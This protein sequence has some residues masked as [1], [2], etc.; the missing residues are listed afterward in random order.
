MLGDLALDSGSP[1]VDVADSAIAIPMVIDI[2]AASRMTNGDQLGGVV[3]DMGAYE[4]RFV[5]LLAPSSAPI[6]ETTSF[7]I[8]SE[9]GSWVLMAGTLADDQLIPGAGILSIDNLPTMLSFGAFG[10]PFLVLS[11][12]T[13]SLPWAVPQ[14]GALIG[15]ELGF[16][17]LLVP[18]V[19]GPSFSNRVRLRFLP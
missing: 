2:E 16:Q 3:A 4:R 19:G 13:T 9:P 11:P 14:L 17:A 5:S 12:T 6:G 7:A 18:S 1:C 10:S 15:L 8:D